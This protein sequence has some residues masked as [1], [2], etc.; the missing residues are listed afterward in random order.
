MPPWCGT[1]HGEN[2]VLGPVVAES[3]IHPLA[4]AAF[5]SVVALSLLRRREARGGQLLQAKPSSGQLP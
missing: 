4:V 2:R 5:G 3:A 1:N